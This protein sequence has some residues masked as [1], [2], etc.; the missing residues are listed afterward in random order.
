MGHKI[1]WVN[2]LQRQRC[3]AT[4][5][6]EPAGAVINDELSSRPCSPAALKLD[7]DKVDVDKKRVQRSE[8][9]FDLLGMQIFLY[10]GR[11]NVCWDILLL[12]STVFL[13]YNTNSR[14]R[15]ALV[16]QL[17]RYLISIFNVN[18]CTMQ[19]AQHV[20]FPLSVVYVRVFCGPVIKLLCHC[21]HAA[22]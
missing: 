3:L 22:S 10:K 14:S 13:C 18:R 8:G 17:G 4:L 15:F 9:H 16:C 21:P 19:C 5:S 2:V 11:T 20:V 12:Y 7:T 1:Y 6:V